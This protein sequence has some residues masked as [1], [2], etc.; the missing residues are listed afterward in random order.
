MAKGSVAAWILAFE[1]FLLCMDVHVLLK[2]LSKCEG[3]EAQHADVLFD[4]R[5]GGHVSPQ[6]EAGSVGLITARHFAGV[7]VF[8]EFSDD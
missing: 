6:G 3:F 8:H 2:V 1:W 5:V 7:W 4:C